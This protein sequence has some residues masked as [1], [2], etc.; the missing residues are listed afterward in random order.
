MP[1]CDHFVYTTA[2]TDTKTGY[3]IVAKSN[4]IDDRVLRRLTGYFFPLG[5]NPTEFKKSKSLLPIGKERVAYS[6]VKNVGI[7]HDG[8]NGTLYNHT[9]VMRKADFEKIGCDTRILDRYFID[10]YSIR[11][12]LD[13]ISIRPETLDLDFEYLQGLDEDLLDGFLFHLFKKNKIAIAKITDDEFIQNALSLVPPQIRLVPF[14]T[15]VLDPARQT[16]YRIIQI[17]NRVQSNLQSNYVTINSTT[18]PSSRPARTRDAG[19]TKIMELL[20][21]NDQDGIFKL[22]EDF[23]SIA[24]KVS[25]T[26]N[27]Q[28]KEVFDKERLEDL[29]ERKKFYLL[30]CEVRD[31]YSRT[32]FNHAPPG[33]VLNVTK[34]IKAI[35]KRSLKA[36]EKEKLEERDFERLFAIVKILLDCLNYINQSDEKTISDE[37]HSKVEDEIKS[38]ELMLKPY[39]QA[40]RVMCDYAFDPFEYFRTMFEN[41]LDS[42]YSI[43]LFALGRKRW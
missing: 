14:S 33:V 19:I 12:K 20:R 10:D 24:S 23:E 32:D 40:D 8:R 26:K 17:P 41:V 3:Q 7:G 1:V 6:T 5:V 2:K 28:I 22:H 39:P 15:E 34:K 4:G 37:M 27:V 30:L 42:T 16:E 11:G 29:A 31:L 21:E 25:K 38:I 18:S 13:Q 43:M 36:N 9:M 35:T